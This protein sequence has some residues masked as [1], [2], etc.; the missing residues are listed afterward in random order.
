VRC[1]PT[2]PREITTL[3]KHQGRPG[4]EFTIQTRSST[5]CRRAAASAPDTPR[6]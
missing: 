5:C 2:R 1:R 6:S 3:E 4:L